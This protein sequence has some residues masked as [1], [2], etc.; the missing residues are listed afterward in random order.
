MQVPSIGSGRALVREF[1]ATVG[2]ENIVEVAPD[3]PDPLAYAS[4]PGD[5]LGRPWWKLAAALTL[6]QESAARRVA[7]ADDDITDE[8]RA[9]FDAG[10]PRASLLLAPRPQVGLTMQELDALEHALLD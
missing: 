8:V 7:W 5:V 3:P 10:W 6:A 9:Q 2:L 1:A 4:R